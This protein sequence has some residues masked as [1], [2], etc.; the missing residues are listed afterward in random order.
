MAKLVQT[1]QADADH[2]AGLALEPPARACAAGVL[3]TGAIVIDMPRNCHE[4]E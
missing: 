3:H 1:N 4:Y 2:I